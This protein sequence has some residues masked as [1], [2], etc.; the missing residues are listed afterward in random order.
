MIEQN[1]L[2]QNVRVE[3]G[4]VKSIKLTAIDLGEP[5]IVKGVEATAIDSTAVTKPAFP[6]VTLTPDRI[7]CSF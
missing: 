2:L 4:I 1:Q 7:G 3:S 5:V 6:E